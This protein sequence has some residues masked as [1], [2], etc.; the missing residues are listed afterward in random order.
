MTDILTLGKNPANFVPLTPISFLKRANDVYPEYPATVWEST[1]RTSTWRETWDTSQRVATGLVQKL[2]VKK[3]DVVG[4][5]ARN[6]RELFECHYAVPMS[7]GVLLTFNF[8][9]DAETIRYSLEF[10]K[11]KVFLVDSAFAG[12]VKEVLKLLEKPGDIIIVDLPDPDLPDAE[13]LGKFTWA[14]LA[15]TPAGLDTYFPDDEMQPICLNYTSGT[16]ARPKGAIY[17][18]RGAYLTAMSTVAAW[19]IKKHGTHMQTVPM[20]HCNGWTVPWWAAINATKLVLMNNAGIKAEKLWSFI[21]GNKVD[22]FGGAPIILQLIIN[23]PDAP[24]LW[25]PCKVMTAGA[26]PTPTLLEGCARHGF[27]VMQVYGLTETYGHVVMCE[28]HESWKEKS[29]SEQAELKALQG[30]AFPQADGIEVWDEDGKPVPH[31]GKTTGEIMIKGNCVMT[32]YLNNPE[33][34]AAA[35]KGGWFHS[36]DAGVIYPDGYL[37]IRDRFK[38]IIIS[39]GENISSIAVEAGV[40]KHPAV[41]LAAVVSMP[42]EK[43]GETPCCFFEVKDGAEVPS[44]TELRDHCKATMSR[45]MCPARFIQETLPK[46][47]TG[48]IQKYMLRD[49]AKTLTDAKAVLPDM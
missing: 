37:Q 7:Q 27:E 48:K 38:D 25:G 11:A 34:N 23:M 35:F 47:S 22:T 33:A 31:D 14:D 26:P 36:G 10:A 4:V 19:E 45:Y 29:A 5:I 13:R 21:N 28:P 46:T 15:A 12:A 44:E 40:A 42:H 20:F 16:T 32:G 41:A 2:G 43:W 3:G 1:D 17:N 49:K 39:G 6:T 9:L 8:R 18:H 24:K 30:V